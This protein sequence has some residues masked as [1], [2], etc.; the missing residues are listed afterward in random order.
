MGKEKVEGR[1]KSS[2]S[3][4]AVIVFAAWA[5]R[6]IIAFLAYR[7]ADAGQMPRLFG[8]LGGGPLFGGAGFRDSTARPR[9]RDTDIFGLVWP[10][11]FDNFVYKSPGG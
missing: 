5:H 3:G 4:L 8:N 10:R 2:D 1:A 7:G 9:G 11:L 6:L